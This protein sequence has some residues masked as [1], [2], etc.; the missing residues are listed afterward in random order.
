[1]CSFIHFLLH[2]VLRRFPLFPYSVMLLCLLFYSYIFVIN[3]L[4]KTLDNTNTLVTLYTLCPSL[5]KDACLLGPLFLGSFYRV[6]HLFIICYLLVRKASHV[7]TSL[8]SF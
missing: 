7:W 6:M 8:E 5:P 1:M 3:T 4:S 2:M